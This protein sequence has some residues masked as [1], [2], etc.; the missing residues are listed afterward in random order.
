MWGSHCRS[1]G[2]AQWLQGCCESSDCDPVSLRIYC[3][4][5]ALT[6]CA[7]PFGAF[8]SLY[9]ITN[10]YLNQAVGCLLPF[11]FFKP[12][13]CGLLPL[14]FRYCHWLEVNQYQVTYLNFPNK[15]SRLQ[16]TRRK[17]TW[18]D[19]KWRSSEEME[20]G[21][22]SRWPQWVCVCPGM[23]HVSSIYSRQ[24]KSLGSI[25]TWIQM[26]QLVCIKT[27]A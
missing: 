17:I 5:T 18:G 10:L 2:S 14:K 21:L 15:C 23:Q 20:D 8:L 22:H 13:G 1:M 3:K 27:A 26:C 16:T 6:V 4:I 11:S 24:M 19:C 12:E 9:Y 25:E 7:R